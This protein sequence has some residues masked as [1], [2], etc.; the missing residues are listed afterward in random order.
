MTTV[1]FRV[2]RTVR[3]CLVFDVR[4]AAH[5]APA[6]H[7]PS[8]VE[9]SVDAGIT[10]YASL[11]AEGHDVGIATIGPTDCW[12]PPGSGDRHRTAARHLFATNPALSPLPHDDETDI[13]QATQRLKGRLPAD[14]QVLLFAPLCD[15]RMLA[16]AVR[17]DAY[18]FAVTVISPDPTTDETTG[19]V[20]E[21]VQRRLRIAD[22]R[23]R[24]I[25][26]VDWAADDDLGTAIAATARRWS[27]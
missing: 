7:E 24:A 2:E 6:A 8:A 1:E 21:R 13:Y 4:A 22:L 17:L 18:G 12:L 15:D 3:V 5:R 19:G 23:A 9:R 16:T 10:A 14:A 20:Y 27:E 11:T 25:P 26:V